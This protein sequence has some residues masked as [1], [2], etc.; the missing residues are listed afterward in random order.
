MKEVG[1]LLDYMHTYPNA[2]LHFFAGDMQLAV[3]SDAAYLV[4][5]GAKSRFAGNF[6]LRAFPNNLNYN[7]AP[8]N[9]PVH[10]KCRTIKS[11]VCLVAEVECSGIFHNC[12]TAIV[13]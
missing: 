9:A 11:V 6:Y 12:Q 3:D 8:N 10:T 7:D 1:Q 13:I 5:S 2:K 4:L